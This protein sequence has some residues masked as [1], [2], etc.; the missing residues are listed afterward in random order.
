MIINLLS[1]QYEIESEED[2]YSKITA[3]LHSL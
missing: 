1:A 2:K 3:N